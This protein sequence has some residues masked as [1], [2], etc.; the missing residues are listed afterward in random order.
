[1]YK[2]YIALYIPCWRLTLNYGRT[3]V[4]EKLQLKCLVNTYN[5]RLKVKLILCH[6]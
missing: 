4:V 6:M 5:Y 1:M 2:S 3:V